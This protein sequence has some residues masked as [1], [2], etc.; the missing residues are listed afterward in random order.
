MALR[1]RLT[2]T[3][4]VRHD[5]TLNGSNGPLSS[6]ASQLPTTPA[7]ASLV[8]PQYPAQSRVLGGLFAISKLSNKS[9]QLEEDISR[10]EPDELFTRYTVAGVKTIA[11][12]LR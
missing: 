1:L 8:A 7:S 9:T 10:L 3:P 12:R 6:S 2:T 11:A 4:S 5:S